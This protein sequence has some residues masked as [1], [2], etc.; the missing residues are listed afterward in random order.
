MKIL[1]VNLSPEA[2]LSDTR[3]NSVGLQIA[4]LNKNLS[5]SLNS[6]ILWHSNLTNN[7]ISLTKSETSM[8]SM[9]V[10]R[11][12]FQS[13]KISSLSR[14][15][16][17][18]TR[19]HLLEE[20][21]FT[22]KEAPK[23]YLLK[24]Q[25]PSRPKFYS[26]SL[27]IRLLCLIC[28]MLKKIIF[29]ETIKH[30][31]KLVVKIWQTRIRAIQWLKSSLLSRVTLPP[32]LWVAMISRIC[33]IELYSNNSLTTMVGP[34][35]LFKPT[36]TR[37]S[38]FKSPDWWNKIW[39][40]WWSRKCPVLA[41]EELRYRLHQMKRRVMNWIPVGW[42]LEISLKVKPLKFKSKTRLNF[43]SSKTAFCKSSYSSILLEVILCPCSPRTQKWWP[44]WQASP[45]PL[46]EMRVKWSHKW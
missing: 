11:P 3:R 37:S 21:R 43:N 6:S 40:L 1:M 42:C 8:P 36:P 31:P 25:I 39:V 30:F 35:I 20:N 33:S 16:I 19:V 14:L 17:Q 29:R 7:R 22:R 28:L 9:L 27:L 26:L 13:L 46:K 2:I 24:W 32:A 23:T 4:C 41:L 45:A 34:I 38:K 44:P 5:N 15:K 12:S 18:R 10:P